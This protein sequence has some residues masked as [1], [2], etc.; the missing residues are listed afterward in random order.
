MHAPIWIFAAAGFLP[1]AAAWRHLE[2]TSLRHALLW[3]AAAYGSWGAVGVFQ[4]SLTGEEAATLRRIALCLGCAPGV[5]VLGA[6]RPHVGAWNFVVL[7]LLGVLLLPL[8]EDLFLGVR[9][10]GELRT[11]FVGAILAVTVLNYLPTTRGCAALAAGVGWAG[12]FLTL[13]DP[14]GIGTLRPVFAGTIFDLLLLAVP[15]LAWGGAMFPRGGTEFDRVWRGFRNA[16]GLVW[17]HRVREQ[18]NAA[19]RNAG[20]PVVL[21]WKGLEKNAD[22]GTPDD[23]ITTSTLRALLKRFAAPEREPAG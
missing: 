9:S 2:G 16:F 13:V 10:H 1:L 22:R 18:F 6:R 15:W 21:T 8:L 12:Q 14:A 17:G 19:A 3:G 23:A 20:W 11:F 7:G 5:A 4:D